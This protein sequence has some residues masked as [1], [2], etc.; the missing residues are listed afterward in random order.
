MEGI[1]NKHGM[2]AIGTIILI[3]ILIVAGTVVY[4][5]YG[6]SGLGKNSQSEEMTM[7]QDEVKKSVRSEIILVKA[8]AEN[9]VNQKDIL[10]KIAE[11]KVSLFD[12]YENGSSTAIIDFENLMGFVT[13]IEEAV[14]NGS[15]DVSILIESFV[16]EID[17]TFGIE[18]EV[19]V[20]D[21]GTTTEVNGGID[22]TGDTEEM[23][24]ST[25]DESVEGGMGVDSSGEAEL[26]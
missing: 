11:I 20:M 23:N 5:L 10:D 19:K 25:D 7:R 9:D 12:A 17:T 2:S 18:T 16:S 4:K 24:D 22:N 13:E 15:E 3:I 14:T 1:Q 21:D 8:M 26:R 6:T